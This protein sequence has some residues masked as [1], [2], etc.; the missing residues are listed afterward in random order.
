MRKKLKKYIQGSVFVSVELILK[1]F[2]DFYTT[3]FDVLY[4]F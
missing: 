1:P 2:C 4:T 3:F